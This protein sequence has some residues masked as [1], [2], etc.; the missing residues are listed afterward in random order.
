MKFFMLFI[1]LVFLLALLRYR[2]KDKGKV[3]H[4]PAIRSISV[5]QLK[6]KISKGASLQ[7]VDVRTPLEYDSGYLHSAVNINYLS[8][9]FV[10]KFKV[11]H[12]D[13]PLYLYCRSGH[14][15]RRAA[16]LLAQEKFTKIYDLEGGILQWNKSK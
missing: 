10:E 9:N 4:H 3:K 8:K 13:E 1:G 5:G 6:E 2:Q 7:L 15:S 12:K 14:R 11:Y 16:S